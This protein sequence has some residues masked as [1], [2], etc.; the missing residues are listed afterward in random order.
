MVRA[1]AAVLALMAAAP[2]AAQPSVPD[3]RAPDPE[4]ILII[5][6]TKGRVIVEMRPEIAPQAVGRIKAL[7]R[8]GYY[9]GAQFYRVERGYMAQGGDKGARTFRSDLPDLKAEFTFRRT[10]ALPFISIRT[11]P[12]GEAG[13]VGATPV[14]IGA[15]GVGHVNYCPGVAAMAHYAGADSANSQFFLMTGPAPQL[16]KTFTAWGRVVAGLAAVKA[17]NTGNPPASPDRMT[18][19]RVLADMPQDQRPA[20]Q[21][22][23]LHGPAFN[24]ALRKLI[25]AR[26]GGFSLC[27]LELAA[28]PA[29]P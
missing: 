20:L 11:T 10:E 15:D 1:L 9:D 7:A 4:N 5:D 3:W 16:E 18:R 8:R 24:E 25:Q 12:S 27:D 13:F 14:R 17:L 28:V 21:L 6:T 23:D 2:A 29:A 26:S 22:M 19:V